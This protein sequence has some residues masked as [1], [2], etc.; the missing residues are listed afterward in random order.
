MSISKYSFR[1]EY[2]EEL[3]NGS[4]KVEL[5][6]KVANQNAEEGKTF[7]FLSSSL[8]ASYKGY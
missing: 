5:N 8:I 1:E 6:S 4:Q 7:L 2:I 3:N